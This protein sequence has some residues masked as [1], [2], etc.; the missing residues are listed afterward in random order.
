LLN[1]RILLVST[2]ISVV[3]WGCE[4]VAF[5]YVLVGL[6]VDESVLLLLQATFIFAASTLLGLVSLLPGGLGASEISSAGLL[7]TLVGMSGSSAATAT[8]IIRFGTLWF[9][10]GLGVLALMW[11][12]QRYRQH[13]DGEADETLTPAS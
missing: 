9:G 5:Y 3:S 1:W 12:R 13:P 11:F 10:V 2:V 7:I 8:I 4:C 6:G